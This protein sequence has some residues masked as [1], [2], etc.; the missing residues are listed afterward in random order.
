MIGKILMFISG[1]IT[2]IFIGT[3]FGELIINRI[4]E[5]I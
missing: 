4:T 1:L 2:G 3:F 5:L